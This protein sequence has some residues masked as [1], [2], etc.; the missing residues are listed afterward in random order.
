MSHLQQV[1]FRICQ[2]SQLRLNTFG[3]AAP[4][5][6]VYFAQC[7][8]QQTGWPEK[9]FEAH[10]VEQ[11]KHISFFHNPGNLLLYLVRRSDHDREHFGGL[12][13]LM[14]VPVD[15]SR[16][17][18]QHFTAQDRLEFAAM[19]LGMKPVLLPGRGFDDPSYLFRTAICLKVAA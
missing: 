6:T 8:A 10:P 11:S 14:K 7:A 2:S 16:K 4:G 1:C 19:V 12:V 13:Q 9:K 5:C 18:A 17:E 15:R 3:D